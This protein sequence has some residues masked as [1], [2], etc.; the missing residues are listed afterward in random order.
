M[1]TLTNITTDTKM[2]QTKAHY[3][4]LFLEMLSK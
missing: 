4:I 1:S 3:D 2:Y